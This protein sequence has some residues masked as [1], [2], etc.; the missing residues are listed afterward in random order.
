MSESEKY[1]AQGRAYASLKQARSNIATIK[2]ALL[3]H[4][5]YFADVERLLTQLAKEP[6]AAN[7]AG[8]SLAGHLETLLEGLPDGKTVA[9]LIDDLAGQSAWASRIEEQISKF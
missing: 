6:N 2:A 4:A 8:M 7:A 9:K 5:R 1:E 3:H